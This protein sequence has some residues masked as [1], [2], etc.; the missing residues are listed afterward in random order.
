M[1][2][3]TLYLWHCLNLSNACEKY[4]FKNP[5]PPQDWRHSHITKKIL[6]LMMHSGHLLGVVEIVSVDDFSPYI[7]FVN[8]QFELFPFFQMDS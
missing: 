4:N 6:R 5:Q 2:N 7:K 8:M 1:L 3:I